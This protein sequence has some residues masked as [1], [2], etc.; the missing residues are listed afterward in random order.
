VGAFSWGVVRER[1][2]REI[3]TGGGGVRS[4]PAGEWVPPCRRARARAQ[5]HASSSAGSGTTAGRS[6]GRKARTGRA[7]G[8]QTFARK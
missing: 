6:R 3:E 1:G 5:R 2:C 4:T 8:G 7:E